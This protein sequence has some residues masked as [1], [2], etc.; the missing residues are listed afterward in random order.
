MQFFGGMSH[1]QVLASPLWLV[2]VTFDSASVGH[3][4]APSWKVPLHLLPLLKRQ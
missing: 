3:V 1:I 4:L 2:S